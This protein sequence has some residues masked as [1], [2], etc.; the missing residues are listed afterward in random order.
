M[1]KNIIILIIFLCLNLETQ[2]KDK[3]LPKFLAVNLIY[4]GDFSKGNIGFSSDYKLGTIDYFNEGYYAITTNPQLYH[5]GFIKC[6]DHTNDNAGLMMVFDSYTIP[7]KVIWTQTISIKPY[8]IYEFSM[9]ATKLVY[10]KDSYLEIRINDVPL[11]S[12]FHVTHTSG[13]WS[14]FHRKW[15]SNAETT[16]KI[17]IINTTLDKAGNDLAI[18]DISF[19]DVSNYI[20][21][22]TPPCIGDE[23]TLS[24]KYPAKTYKW[25]NGEIS[26]TIKV[27]EAGKYYVVCTYDNLCT[28]IDTIEISSN[29]YSINIFKDKIKDTLCL[30]EIYKLYTDK[31]FKKY[32]W[33][34]KK[35]GKI[36]S[37]EDTCLINNN[38][39]FYL[40]VLDSN[41]CEYTSDIIYINT[42]E[43]RKSKLSFILNRDTLHYIDS[44]TYKFQKC[45]AIRIINNSSFESII[46]DTY[47]FNNTNFSV[48][49]SQ[50]PIKIKPYD[51]ANLIVCF[52]PTY[53]GQFV[54]TLNILTQCKNYNIPFLSYGVLNLLSSNSKCKVELLLSDT[55]VE[56]SNYA[57]FYSPVPNP[58]NNFISMEYEIIGKI[59][60]NINSYLIDI[61]SN[62]LSNYD[63]VPQS[64]IFNSTNAKG[65]IEYN[66][67]NL[68]SGYYLLIIEINNKIIS[69]PVI[70]LR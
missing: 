22:S 20:I 66:V 30:S 18:D 46:E 65:K 56:N 14:E 60:A 34:N 69:F 11:D 16:A 13:T 5:P 29:K 68:N 62:K 45:T 24:L 4:N 54:D 51:S 6:T 53:I 1:I 9:W 39:E 21:A 49:Q 67:E 2:S 35:S 33:Y 36:I 3:D 48:P 25:S 19:I 7:N 27:K 28:S 55:D 42:I 32:E 15:C 59:K 70:I 23:I 63:I 43:D 10:Y 57:M 41:G 31:I 40:V 37:D 61:L 26:P 47:F 50:L 12:I 17:E 58:A 8:R 38:G 64:Q 52:S 44:V